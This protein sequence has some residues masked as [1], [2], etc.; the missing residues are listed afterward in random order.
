[1]I[2]E[3]VTESQ[4]HGWFAVRCVFQHAKLGTYEERITLWETTDFDAALQHAEREAVEYVRNLDDVQYV[5]LAQAFRLFDPP[6]NGAE[7]FSLMRASTLEPDAYVT[8]FFDTGAERQQ[9]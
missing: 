6:A 4:G 2:E 9:G 1:M 7:V 3:A 5:G 8:R